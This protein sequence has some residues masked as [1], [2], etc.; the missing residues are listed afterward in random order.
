MERI[1]THYI[2]GKRNDVVWENKITTRNSIMDTF[3]DVTKCCYCSG[4]GNN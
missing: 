2:V 3:K 1:C 4:R